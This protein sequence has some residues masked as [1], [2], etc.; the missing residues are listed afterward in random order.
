MCGFYY[1]FVVIMWEGSLLKLLKIQFFGVKIQGLSCQCT[2]FCFFCPNMN[3]KGCGH[4]HA[5]KYCSDDS[6]S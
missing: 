6:D 2:I 5:L 4:V 1:N 3:K